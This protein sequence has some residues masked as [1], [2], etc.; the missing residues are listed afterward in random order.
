MKASIF[1][2]FDELWLKI[3]VLFIAALSEGETETETEADGEGEGGLVSAPCHL[4]A[5]VLVGI[6][7]RKSLQQSAS[8]V[9]YFLC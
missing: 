5:A 8:Y 3:D 1:G 7:C 2:K 6:V 4:A 9:G